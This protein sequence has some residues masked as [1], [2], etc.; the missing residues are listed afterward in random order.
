MTYEGQN[1]DVCRKAFI[2]M[3]GVGSDWVDYLSKKRQEKTNTAISDQR[4]KGGHR[5]AVP[6]E[7]ENLVHMHIGTLQVRAS[8]YT[9]TINPHRQYLDFVDQVSMSWLFDRYREWLAEEHPG[10]LP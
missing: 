5:N 8:H 2:S 3:H 6:D 4:G 7:V 1:Y 10:T 9:R